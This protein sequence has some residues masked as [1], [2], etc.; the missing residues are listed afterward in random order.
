METLAENAE[1]MRER[2]MLLGSICR[3]IK[4]HISGGMKMKAVLHDICKRY[5]GTLLRNGKG[6]Q[7]TLKLSAGNLRRVYRKWICEGES[8]KAFDLDYKPGKQKA[9][10]ELVMEF[11]RQCSLP[12]VVR[13]SVAMDSLKKEWVNGLPVPGLGTWSEWFHKKYP[14]LTMPPHAPEFPFCERTLYR[15]LPKKNIR[16]LGNHGIAAFLRES[17]YIPRTTAKLRPCELFVMD[18]KRPD[19]YVIDDDT[20]KVTDVCIYLMQEVSA[21]RIVGFTARPAVAMNSSDVDALVA[22]VLESEGYGSTY[23]THILC[24]HGT[25][26]MSPAAQQLIEAVTDGH[27]KIHRTSM[28]SG[29]RAAGFAADKASG[30]WQ[31]KGGLESFM[32]KLDLMLMMLPGQRGNKH[33]NMPANLMWSVTRKIHDQESGQVTER[34][35]RGGE[36][37]AAEM[38]AQVEVASG[39]KFGLD[40]SLLW[41]TEFNLLLRKLIEQHNTSRDHQYEG[42]GKVTQKSTAPGIWEDMYANP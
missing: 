25:V 14:E 38:L 16:R 7:K 33:E 42:F 24:E 9:P 13:S 26:A 40:C 27:V 10:L 32:G 31:G 29:T 21:R 30:H 17:A 36:A 37:A 20:G 3:E 23:T 5:S 1:W 8:L 35:I 41:M 12:G 4:G 6:C 19:L 18:D 11:Q 39:H 34:V 28:D 15:Y 2:A 22:R